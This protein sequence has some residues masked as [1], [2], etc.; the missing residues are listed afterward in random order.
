MSDARSQPAPGG[1]RLPA[2]PGGA[3]PFGGPLPGAPLGADPRAG[4]GL[5]RAALGR[6]RGTLGLAAALSAGIAVL[7]LT[8]PI[9]MVQVYDR[10]LA[11]GSVPT[12]AGLFVLAMG[13]YGFLGL[14]SYLRGRIL[15]RA[16][17][18]I[19]D[20]LAE[21][22]FRAALRAA[23]GRG[24][25]RGA[26]A[27]KRRD[28]TGA[29]APAD[30]VEELD[31]VRA[32][33]AGPAMAGLMDLPFVPLFLVVTFLVHPAVGLATLGG[34]TAA[35]LVALLN[36][37]ATRRVLAEGAGMQAATARFT[38]AL[39]GDA[40]GL[41]AMGMEDHV[42]AR[43]MRMH[44]AAAG[45]LQQGAERGEAYS[46]ASRT[47]RMMLQS[48]LITV[49]AL[50]AIRGEISAGMII[51]ISIVAGRALAPLD[52]A[53][54]Q[55]PLIE[56]ALRA[57]R[58][59]LA[60]DLRRPD[61][62]PTALP[63]M[64]GA[65][66]LRDV[67]VAAGA[68]GRAPV[69][70]GV[71]LDVAPG[72]ALGV[73]GHSASGKSTLAR[74]L[75]GALI[76]DAGEA[77]IDGAEHAQWD[78]AVLSRALGYL[79]Q[80]VDLL[81]GTVAENIARFD[82]SRTDAEVVAAARL[83]GVHEMILA[84]PRGYGTRIDGAAPLSGGQVQ[85]VGLA[86]AVIGLPR[87]VVLD[88]PNAHLDAPGDAALTRV[89]RALRASGAA[90]VVITH[91]AA[92]LEA[93]SRVVTLERGRVVRDGPRPEADGA[94]EGG[95][96]LA[97]P[98]ARRRTVREV[99]AA[100]RAA[101]AAAAAAVPRPANAP[102]PGAEFAPAASAAAAG[103]APGAARLVPG[104]SGRT[105]GADAPVPIAAPPEVTAPGADPEARPGPARA[106]EVIDWAAWDR[107]RAA[108]LRSGGGT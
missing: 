25:A 24:D 69:L 38:E 65:V 14:Y 13:L 96:R 11:S 58:A 80:R 85:R 84:L 3:D 44:E 55:W 16:A 57:H 5:Y 46:S 52:Q 37:R 51:A 49:G 43:R 4:R 56:R 2:T 98:P 78:R 42:V 30:P 45:T 97:P 103:G 83:A 39:R 10:V 107:G 1:A 31:A 105:D 27:T 100:S 12:L 34:M 20:A 41:R 53:I 63:E 87:L 59:L 26:G 93:V 61:P 70:D 36:R 108:A 74:V 68:R 82:P 76:P 72:E 79:P 32:F 21:P 88:E 7:M 67:T 81:P 71:S 104:P 9:Y 28:G 62:A 95:A 29:G 15:T 66:S 60:A 54:G 19:D 91:R 86:R 106:G 23:D 17:Y 35:A 22:A 40:A 94:E 64:T 8:G 48:I 18:R 99:A 33:V 75:V 92:G 73:T 90:V 6:V 89:V 102:V 50:L 77:R 101:R 47:L